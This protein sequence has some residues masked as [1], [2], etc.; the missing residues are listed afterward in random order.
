MMSCVGIMS[1]KRPV[2]FGNYC[3]FANGPYVC[4]MWAEN[5]QS[6]GLD[7]IECIVFQDGEHSIALVVDERLSE[8]W[9][10]PKLCITGQGWGTRRMCE[11]ICE[12]SKRP[13]GNSLCGCEAPDQG[14][15]ISQ[16]SR[17]GGPWTHHCHHCGRTWTN[18]V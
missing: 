13:V 11:R 1:Q 9:L 7:E 3:S 12:V 4:N 10:Y 18:E 14:P 2:S 16:S 6:C 5:I 8:D 15:R 17:M